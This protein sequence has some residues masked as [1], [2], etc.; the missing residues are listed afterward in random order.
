MLQASSPRVNLAHLA[1]V[2]V[3]R[4]SALVP[5]TRSL[6]SRGPPLFQG[7]GLL[8]RFR[9][10]LARSEDRSVVFF[11]RIRTALARRFLH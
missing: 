2:F 5:R 7:Y 1:A 10:G 11:I 8:A 6:S 3:S 4:K 9:R